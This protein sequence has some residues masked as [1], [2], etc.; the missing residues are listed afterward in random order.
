MDAESRAEMQR[1]EQEEQQREQDQAQEAANYEHA[2]RDLYERAHSFAEQNGCCEK[3]A[4]DRLAGKI[5]LF[6]LDEIKAWLEGRVVA[7][8]GSE[9]LSTDLRENFA[10]KQAI[11]FLTDDREGLLVVSNNSNK[12]GQHR[13]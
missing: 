6:S 9:A 1:E 3:C 10:I 8:V 7:T 5:K 12:E 13:E 4:V 2:M 11:G